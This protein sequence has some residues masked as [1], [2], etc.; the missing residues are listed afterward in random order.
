M[1]R[2]TEAHHPP[3]LPLP[4][5]KNATVQQAAPDILD[6]PAS[7]ADRVDGDEA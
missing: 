2:D 5:L 1:I 7:S 3:E 4:N 6:R